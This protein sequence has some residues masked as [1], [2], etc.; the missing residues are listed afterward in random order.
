ME[1]LYIEAECA[2]TDLVADGDTLEFGMSVGA[3]PTV[4]PRLNTATTVARVR[5]VRQAGATES[6]IVLQWPYRINLQDAN[7]Y[8]FLV[9][10]DTLNIAATS[11]GQAAANVWRFRIYYRF[12][13]IP[14]SEYVGIVSS[15]MT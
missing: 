12:V 3:A 2:T 1:F 6:A 11:S 9:A 15:L 8:G 13:T 5:Y 4:V 7:G 10:A 14:I